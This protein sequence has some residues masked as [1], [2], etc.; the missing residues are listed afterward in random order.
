MIDP[1]DK[2]PLRS[3]GESPLSPQLAMRV[4]MLG[5]IALVLFSIIF[6]KLWF[7]QVLTGDQAV[8]EAANNR[9]RTVAVAAPRGAVLDR[10]GET[11]VENRPASVMQ[12]DPGQLPAATR[13]A[14]ATWGQEMTTWARTP[15]S[16]RGPR[17]KVPAPA[18]A[19]LEKRYAQLAT[20]LGISPKTINERVI[21]QLAQ[22]PYANVRV[23]VDVPTAVRNYLLERPGQFPGVSIDQVYVRRYPG[24]VGAAQLLGAVGQV[25]PEQ[26]KADSFRGVISGA[27]VGQEGIERSYDRYLR[28]SDGTKSITIDAAG[29]L[30]G[31]RI[32]RESRA[33]DSVRTSLDAS[34]QRSGETALASAMS[35]GGTAGAFVALD[36]RD[37]RVLALGSAPTYDPS[38]R[39]KPIPTQADYER[40]FGEAAGAPLF[41]RAISGGYP[42]G[43]I[44]KPITALAALDG[45]VITAD[46]SINDPG[47]L[48]VGSQ[49][50]YNA[51][52]QAN[53]PVSLVRALQVSSDV[54]FYTLGRDA[55]P[56]KGQII[57]SWARKLGL[58][59]A[60]GIDLPGE[61]SGTIP[62]RQWRAQQNAKEIEW[63]KKSGKKCPPDCLYSD[64]RPW[65]VGDNIQLS[66]GQGDVQASPLQMA[67]A[68]S[69]IANGG[70]VVR[71]H[72]GMAIENETGRQLERIEAP[73]LRRVVI[74]PSYQKS[75]LDG[76]HQST[77]GDGTSADVFSG[78]NQSKFPVYGKTGTAER[79]PRPDQSWYA[80]Y[81]P[82]ATK[83]IVIVATV[84]D[85][86]FGAEAAAPAVC[87]MLATWFSQPDRCSSG[88]STTR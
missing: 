60:T 66:V 18:N 65:S 82:S 34:L 87:K 51:G 50:F 15:R 14:A 85:G 26:L 73:P 55:N 3:I 83:P 40:L 16:E 36:P 78:W 1:L 37:G 27:I 39:A 88:A 5:G 53:G 52:R 32:S 7:L 58:D 38:V 21:Q 49:K 86:G 61:V 43:S 69:A 20:V 64:K 24:G 30:K 17:P 25:S 33:G 54:Y 31:Q 4:A 62:D 29:K 56:M 45:G 71:P 68:Y 59:K 8:R 81:V 84:E 79:P 44:F 42:T 9:V 35:G 23:E 67:V 74:D 28:G 19:A 10:N 2:T 80:A 46:R 72:L 70:T 13:E 48:T 63:E 11:L 77:L 75:I 57:Q 22:L 47:V 41:N 6:F 76:L 12:L